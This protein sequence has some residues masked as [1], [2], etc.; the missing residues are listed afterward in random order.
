MRDVKKILY[1]WSEKERMENERTTTKAEQDTKSG[2]NDN[3]QS[4][5][6]IDR[7]TKAKKKINK[8]MRRTQYL[9]IKRA[10]S[11]AAKSP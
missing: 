8:T 3:A 9:T 11:S 6:R 5:T 10:N 1:Q 2:N 4:I 7:K